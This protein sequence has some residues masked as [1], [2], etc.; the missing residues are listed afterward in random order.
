MSRV[1]QLGLKSLN[2]DLN[3]YF[4]PKLELGFLF[5]FF[6]G[7]MKLLLVLRVA[8]LGLKTLSLSSG[9]YFRFKLEF[10]FLFVR[11]LQEPL[12]YYRC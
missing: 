7:S 5:S 4:R 11:F 3:P 2:V 1:V 9:P 10:G 12:S 6:A 8:W